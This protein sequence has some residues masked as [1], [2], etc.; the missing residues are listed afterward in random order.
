RLELIHESAGVHLILATSPNLYLRT[1][2]RSTLNDAV[3]MYM[4]PAE[5]RVF[6]AAKETGRPLFDLRHDDAPLVPKG[7]SPNGQTVLSCTKS[8]G[9]TDDQCVIYQWETRSGKL[10]HSFRL[11]RKKDHEYLTFTADGRRILADLPH[12]RILVLDAYTAQELGRLAMPGAR[13]GGLD[14]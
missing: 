7:F 11:E 3:R 4:N 5:A 9:A 12:H 1:E 8:R 14:Y 10:R 13:P 6:V 2:G